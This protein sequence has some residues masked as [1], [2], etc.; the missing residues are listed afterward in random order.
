MTSVAEY[1]KRVATLVAALRS[2]LYVQATGQLRSC[3]GHCCLGVATEICPV[4]DRDNNSRLWWSGS[5]MPRCVQE[6][7]GFTGK[8]GVYIK[9][10]QRRT[11]WE[12]NDY[13]K[14]FGEIATII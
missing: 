13:G 14:S 4:Y 3:F 10:R 12:D 9:S 11:L 8:D 2:G 7:Y 6:Y 1:R 5:Y